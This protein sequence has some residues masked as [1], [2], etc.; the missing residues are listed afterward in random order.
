MAEELRWLL[1]TV[2]YI[3]FTWAFKLK[4]VNFDFDYV[5]WSKKKKK[6]IIKNKSE[7]ESPN[8]KLHK[9]PYSLG[10]RSLYQ[11]EMLHLAMGLGQK[12]HIPHIHFE[13]K[14][15]WHYSAS[16]SIL[17]LGKLTLT[18]TLWFCPISNFSSSQAHGCELNFILYT[19][20]T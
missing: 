20:S 14:A 5:D 11:F 15:Y 7:V 12:S 6:R 9:L 18:Q 1:H 3:G 13:L 2:L 16:C 19:D 4:E 8:E 17:T 10:Y